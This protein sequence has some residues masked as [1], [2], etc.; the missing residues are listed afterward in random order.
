[1]DDTG[2]MSKPHRGREPANERETTTEA[3]ATQNSGRYPLTCHLANV[4]AI[5]S[6]RARVRVNNHG[7]KGPARGFWQ[8]IMVECR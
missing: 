3:N 5:T 6:T 8:S 7:T 2:D 1:M 4:R